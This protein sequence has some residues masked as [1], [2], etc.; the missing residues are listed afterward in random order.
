M[1]VVY[2]LLVPRMFLGITRFV[3]RTEPC[4]ACSITK[5]AIGI[6]LRLRTPL[7]SNTTITFQSFSDLFRI[8]RLHR[9]RPPSRTR[10][11][12]RS[13]FPHCLRRRF[14]ADRSSSET[15]RRSVS[16][17]WDTEQSWSVPAIQRDGGIG[18]HACVPHQPD[19]PRQGFRSLVNGGI[20]WDLGRIIVVG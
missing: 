10:D 12:V 7:D 18:R 17:T 14:H 13:Y 2:S 16:G 19:R 11:D 3:N 4:A 8:F 1:S 20:G 9:F 6:S 15:H 5:A